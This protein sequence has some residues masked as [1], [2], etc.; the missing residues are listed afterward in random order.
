MALE[1]YIGLMSGTSADGVDAVVAVFDQGRFDRV[2]ASHHRPY[3]AALRASLLANA[4]ANINR[5]GPQGA[6]TGP[7]ARPAASPTVTNV[8]IF[9]LRRSNYL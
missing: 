2:E 5:L 9:I 4:A 1:R 8:V 7:A 3:P 6:L